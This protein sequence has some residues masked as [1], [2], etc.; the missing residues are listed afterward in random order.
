[1]LNGGGKM[2]RPCNTERAKKYRQTKEGKARIY[3]AVYRSMKNHREKQAARV[4]LNKAL[5]K[6]VVISK[7]CHCGKKAEAHHDDYTKPL[8]IKWLCRTHH[9]NYHKRIKVFSVD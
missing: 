1:M 5:K 9:A 3:E 2:C 4:K 8:E 6:G 7:P